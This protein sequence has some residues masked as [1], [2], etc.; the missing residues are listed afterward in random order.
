MNKINFAQFTFYATSDIIYAGFKEE[1]IKIVFFEHEQDIPVIKLPEKF[2]NAV[3]V[4]NEC[5]L[6]LFSRTIIL[7]NA[8]EKTY[9]I[10][11]LS[12]ALI[13]EMKGKIGLFFENGN[14]A[15]LSGKKN[16][17]KIHF[18]SQ[19]KGISLD[20]GI[21]LKQVNQEVAQYDEE[22]IYM[23]NDDSVVYI[24][25][26][27]NTND[28]SIAFD[29][30]GYIAMKLISSKKDKKEY[31]TTIITCNTSI[32]SNNQS[33][34][35]VSGLS[36]NN[37]LSNTLENRTLITE[38]SLITMQ[39]VKIININD[40]SYTPQ[41]F[42]NDN[43]YIYCTRNYIKINVITGKVGKTIKLQE[44]IHEALIPLNYKYYKYSNTIINVKKG[45]AGE[46]NEVIKKKTNCD[47]IC[48]VV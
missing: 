15:F 13:E 12:K 16:I 3:K 29:K 41:F 14:N 10:Y 32:Y 7:I 39:T 34:F 17:F 31:R 8:N 26:I 9:V 38:I 35:F 18:N 21:Q 47:L 25:S 46:E 2:P 24:T 4:K 37:V 28:Y 27:I 23:S 30:A 11:N 44:D 42:R 5:V 48:L 33:M 20:E 6:L 19:C 45:E 40:S 1:V 36:L 22:L 43:L